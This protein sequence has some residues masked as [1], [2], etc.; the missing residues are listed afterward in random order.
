MSDV[1]REFAVDGPATL[2]VTTFSGDIVITEAPAGVVRARISGGGADRFEVE[3]LGDVIRV[4]AERG[5]RGFAKRASAAVS[6]EAPAGTDVELR[7]ASGDVIIRSEVGSVR[8]GLASGDLK[9]GVATGDMTAKTASGD[10]FVES[11]AGMLRAQTASGDIRVDT[12]GSDCEIMTASGDVFIGTVAGRVDVKSASGDATF[13]AVQGDVVV[14]KTVSGNV[15]IG[16]P[17]KRVVE[18]DLHAL[19][20]SLKSAL[21]EG[22]NDAP[23]KTL[24]IKVHTVSGDVYLLDA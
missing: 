8:V 1:R 7:S 9:M 10:L 23:E 13:R 5:N 4:E 19:S 16:I 22:H 3:Q 15:R 12:I 2:V 20:G 6:V 18:V 24:S 11:I 21:T 14:G 17:P